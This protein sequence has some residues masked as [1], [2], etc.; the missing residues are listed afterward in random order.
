MF[1]QPFLERL[2]MGPALIINVPSNHT[3]GAQF[4]ETRQSSPSLW[5][6]LESWRKPETVVL[7]LQTGHGG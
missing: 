2:N 4:D 3:C 7:V 6:V 5:K 1:G